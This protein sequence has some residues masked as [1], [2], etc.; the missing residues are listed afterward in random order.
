MVI[1]EPPPNL[2]RNISVVFPRKEKKVREGHK[3]NNSNSWN[4][5]AVERTFVTLGIAA[6]VAKDVGGGAKNGRKSL[7]SGLRVRRGMPYVKYHHS[8][9][10]SANFLLSRITVITF[11]TATSFPFFHSSNGKSR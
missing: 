1:H 9:M 4:P 11:R 2:V 6:R 3:F 5:N 7:E 10:L 8:R